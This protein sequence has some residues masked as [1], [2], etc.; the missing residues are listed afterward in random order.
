MGLRHACG[1]FG[2]GGWDGTCGRT[3]GSGEKGEK[4]VAVLLLGISGG[5]VCC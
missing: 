5:L 2:D 1:V 3:L 4:G